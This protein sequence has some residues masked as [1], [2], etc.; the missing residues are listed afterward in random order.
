MVN[1][2]EWC[3]SF[4]EENLQKNSIQELKDAT[5]KAG[6]SITELKEMVTKDENHKKTE[7][8]L[9]LNFFMELPETKTKM[10]EIYGK[11]KRKLSWSK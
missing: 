9:R 10:D 2:N 8:E 6:N 7:W 11:W 4:Q 1:L 3:N 5:E